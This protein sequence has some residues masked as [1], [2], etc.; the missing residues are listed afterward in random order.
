V[1]A[2]FLYFIKRRFQSA[3]MILNELRVWQSVSFM[4]VGMC[5]LIAQSRVMLDSLFLSVA[6]V[7][8]LTANTD[9]GET[10]LMSMPMERLSNELL[11]MLRSGEGAPVVT[12]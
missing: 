6:D 8:L 11:K 1:S 5:K 10:V 4:E 12:T 3:K 7:V 9:V 2:A